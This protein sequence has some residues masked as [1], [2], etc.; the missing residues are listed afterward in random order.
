MEET[1]EHGEATYEEG[2]DSSGFFVLVGTGI[3]ITPRP[4][5]ARGLG[6]NLTEIP[7]P[8]ITSGKMSR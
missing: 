7:E 5:L 6:R 8:A 4:I 3:T 1:V 2:F